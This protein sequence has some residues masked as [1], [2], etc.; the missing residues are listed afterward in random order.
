[1]VGAPIVWMHQ[2]HGARVEAVTAPVD[3]VADTDGL[4][5]D[6]PGVALGVL[7][8]DCVP[9]LLADRAAGVVGAAHVGRRGLVA[10]AALRVIDAMCGL[11]ARTDR[12]AVRLGPAICG[13]CY[14][15]PAT[16]QAEVEAVAPGSASTTRQ[17][18]PGVDLK[19]GLRRQLADLA[20]VVDV[21]DLEPVCTAESPLHYSHRRDGVTGRFAGVIVMTALG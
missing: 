4:V 6:V 2:V 11:G 21:N 16:L 7:V 8:A 12:I 3:D 14:E 10:G 5:T 15:V 18:T 20:D 13:R 1:M 17:G 9:V 19:A